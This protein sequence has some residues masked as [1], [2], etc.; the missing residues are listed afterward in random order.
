MR[1]GLIL[2]LLLLLTAGFAFGP[3]AS[4]DP[5]AEWRPERPA[6]TIEG[7]SPVE[8][9]SII[10]E[11][12]RW[13]VTATTAFPYNSIVYL[14]RFDEFGFRGRC[15]G[16][17]IGPDVVLTAGHCLYSADRGWVTEIVVVPGKDGAIE[18]FGAAW[19]TSWFVSPGWVATGAL[20]A[21][22]AIIALA[23]GD[24]RATWFRLADL[25]TPTL[26]GA[27]LTPAV[28]GYA[29][30]R[31]TGTMW[32]G[33]QPAFAA[34]DDLLLYHQVDTTAG[35]S[36]APVFVS[37]E[38]SP[39]YGE[40]IGMHTTGYGNYNGA[41]RFTPTFIAELHSACSQLGC[42]I[43]PPPAQ[44]EAAELPELTERIA[45]AGVQRD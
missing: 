3:G 10:D 22:W 45:V 40:A 13:R 35:T 6:L 25:D 1:Y 20:E 4:A 28:A 42:S 8:G 21:D 43:D 15:T 29:A 2:L 24:A 26:T 44:A 18:P 17:L 19:A 14:E 34:V 38:G 11:D 27:T 23:P 30:D 9:Q 31:P 16:M 39:H 7:D 37:N 36:G 5:A 41:L 32:A 12:E 33:S